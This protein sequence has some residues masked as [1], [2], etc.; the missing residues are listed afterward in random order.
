MYSTNAYVIREA[1]A[2]D[3]DTL[4]LL[5]E[6]DSQRPLQGRALIGEIDGLP[7]AAVSIA[8]GRIV[9]D[10]FQATSHLVPL[11]GLRGRALRTYEQTPSLTARLHAVMSRWRPASPI[12]AGL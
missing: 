6:L 10:P 7:A 11:L 5:A 3:E 9:A 1:T 4:Q 12:T 8:D 2:A